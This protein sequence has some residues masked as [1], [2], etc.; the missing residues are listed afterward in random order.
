MMNEFYFENQGNNTYLIYPVESEKQ[1]DTLTI[2]MLTNNSIA[3]FAPVIY[4]QQ[5]EQIIMKYNVTAKVSVQQLLTGTVEKKH[6]LGIISGILAAINDAEEYM[7]DINSLLFDFDKIFVDVSSGNV[8]MICIPLIGTNGQAP[9]FRN[10]FKELLFSARLNPNEN[11]DYFVAII[12]YLNGGGMF[13][14]EG[15]RGLLEQMTS[16]TNASAK[17]DSVAQHTVQ[18]ENEN[19]MSDTAVLQQSGN[20]QS[21]VPQTTVAEQPMTTS[22]QSV[23]AP[24]QGS[25][26]SPYSEPKG[27][28][29]QMEVPTGMSGDMPEK[30]EKEISWLYLMQHYNKENAALYKEQ[31]EKKKQEEKDK[32]E[33]E[34]QEKKDKK[35]K[36]KKGK[37]K[38]KKSETSVS[39]QSFT[40]AVPGEKPAMPVPGAPTSSPAQAVQGPAM[41]VPSAGVMPQ[42]LV[43]PQSG[44]PM[45]NQTSVNVAPVSGM[46]AQS[47]PSG[48]TLGKANFGE[49]TVLS[50]GGMGETTLL[51]AMDMPG[52]AKSVPYLVR[53]KNHEKILLN[54]PIFRI[55]KEKSYVDYFIA[56]NT[57]ISRSHVNIIVQGEACFIVDTNS[58]NHT[59]V[60][61]QMI[62]SNQEIPLADGASVRL[63]N[64]EFEFHL[65]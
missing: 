51:S 48:F 5:N 13:S 39:Q 23:I 58:T 27:A 56:D 37:D 31:K 2:G 32:K 46:Y 35:D 57:A 14:L 21:Y 65:R 10:Y 43:T 59:Y 15:F 17:A 42:A 54:K 40:F 64:E 1:L 49:T 62:Q 7:L 11:N 19:S 12:N 3:N 24:N 38:D 25:V 8:A 63:A 6:V 50:G 60:N 18:A 55:G 26:V 28:M 20:T 4:T 44:V 30:D 41:A 33:K 16:S 9:D 29:P 61:G 52:E 36:G 45:T 34:K 22:G 53:T 47:V